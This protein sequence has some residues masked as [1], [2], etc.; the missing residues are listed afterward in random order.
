VKGLIKQGGGQESKVPNYGLAI[1]SNK[2]WADEERVI[3]KCRGR[4]AGVGVFPT[5]Q[6]GNL[7]GVSI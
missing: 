4:E 7:A 5:I 1:A 6:K 3:H 2:E